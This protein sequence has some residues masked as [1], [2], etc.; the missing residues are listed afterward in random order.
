M[1]GKPKELT[2]DSIL[3]KVSI[4]DLWRYYIP[5]V[6]VKKKFKSP[7]RE[8]NNPSAILF[9]SK[10]GSILF[11]DFAVG[12]LNIWQFLMQK[13]NLTFIE[14]LQVV[15]NDFNLNLTTKKIL[16]KPTMD[17]LGTVLK[18]SVPVIQETKLPIKVRDWCNQDSLYWKQF[19]I[20]LDILDRY[21]IV[22]LQ[23][24]WIN[25]SLIYWYTPK[26]PAYSYEFGLGK[27]KIYRPLTKKKTDKWITNAD[28][29]IIQGERLLEFKN[30][31]LIITKAYKDVLVLN[32]LGFESIASQAESVFIPE[33]KLNQM[34]VKYSKIFILWDNDKTGKKYSEKFSSLYGIIPIFVPETSNCKDISDFRKLN[35]KEETQN[36]LNTLIYGS[37]KKDT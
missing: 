26:D 15:D 18:E 34:K 30:P 9:V 17:Y 16:V 5:G 1:Y 12:T 7:L 14:A 22:P 10:E 27:R 24:Y 19:D 23:N 35:T 29:S 21:K 8:D 13:Y 32:S 2:I 36:L 20:T 28:S 3:Q 6:E 37:R 25:D 33:K 11:Q 31:E 4:L